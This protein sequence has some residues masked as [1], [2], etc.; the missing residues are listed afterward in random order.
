MRQMRQDVSGFWQFVDR[1]ADGNPGARAAR[2][3]DGRPQPRRRAA[4][5][6]RPTKRSK[7]AAFRAI[8]TPSPTA[9]TRT[10]CAARSALT[11]GA[12]TRA[13]PTCRRAARDR[14]VGHAYA[15][16]R[17]RGARP[18]PGRVDALSS[19]AAARPR[20]RRRRD[21]GAGARRAGGEHR[22]RPALRLP[23]RQHRAPVRV[24]AERVGHG[25]ALRRPAERERP[26]PRQAPAGSRRHAH[27]RLLD[28]ARRRC[29]RAPQRPAAV[30]HRARRR[31]LLPARHPRPALPG[32]CNEREPA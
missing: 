24:R 18:G 6:A 21:A 30:R 3:R 14:L 31:L 16:L 32:H 1:C 28:S 8:S 22:D 12:A 20:V 7:A 9:P 5:S 4:R 2:E 13:M 29:R 10:A 11:S 15:R 26:A 17:Q 27:R 25:R 19:P 23:R